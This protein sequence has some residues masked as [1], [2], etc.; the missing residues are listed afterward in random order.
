M[1][2]TTEQ[3]LNIHPLEAPGT[4]SHG[5]LDK[6]G[7]DSNSQPHVQSKLHTGD[8]VGRAPVV[9]RNERRTESRKDLTAAPL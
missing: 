9:E 3:E 1:L 2:S 7:M 5:L 6:V 8:G 4:R